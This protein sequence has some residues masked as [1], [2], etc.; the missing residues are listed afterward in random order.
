MRYFYHKR[1]NGKNNQL[2]HYVCTEDDMP[3][4]YD[5][6]YCTRYVEIYIKQPLDEYFEQVISDGATSY[7]FSYN[8]GHIE[9]TKEEY[10]EALF[11]D[12]L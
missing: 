1:S 11:I 4:L 8:S 9:I 6:S 3:R 12:K 10:E 5:G 7:G 2:E